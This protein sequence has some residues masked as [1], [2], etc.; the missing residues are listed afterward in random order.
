MLPMRSIFFPLIVALL[1]TWLS[2]HGNRLYRC[3]R[4][5]HT[6]DVCPFIALKF[7]EA[8][9][10]GLIFWRFLPG[11]L[12][13]TPIAP[14]KNAPTPSLPPPPQKKKKNK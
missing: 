8:F 5:Q 1:K 14:N 3:N 6:K 2:H 9:S 12:F 13:I 4:Y 10:S 11:F 7:C